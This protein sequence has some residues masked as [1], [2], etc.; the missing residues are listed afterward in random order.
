MHKVVA[1]RFR[2]PTGKG[3]LVCGELKM[4]LAVWSGLGGVVDIVLSYHN[5]VPRVTDSRTCAASSLATR[6]RELATGCK[7]LQYKV[8]PTIYSRTSPLLYTG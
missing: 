1:R 3:Q 5:V 2:T 7:S 6:Q 4:P 8:T